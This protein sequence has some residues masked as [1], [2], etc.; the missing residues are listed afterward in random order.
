MLGGDNHTLVRWTSTH[1]QQP[2]RPVQ[3]ATVKRQPIGHPPPKKCTHHR[4]TTTE[5]LLKW[6][7]LVETIDMA[8]RSTKNQVPPERSFHHPHSN[9]ND[10]QNGGFSQ[11][12]NGHDY[13]QHRGTRLFWTCFPLVLAQ[14]LREIGCRSHGVVWPHMAAYIGIRQPLCLTLLTCSPPHLTKRPTFVACQQYKGMFLN[15]GEPRA[16]HMDFFG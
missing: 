16:S 5:M 10:I 9:R 12:G 14:R 11:N 1:T 2:P 13:Y 6:Q 3:H 8:T 15:Q 4:E 7:C